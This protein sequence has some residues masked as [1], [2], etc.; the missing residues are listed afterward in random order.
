MSS[1]GRWI[2]QSAINRIAGNTE[3]PRGL[4]DVIPCLGIG[5]QHLRAMP[6]LK[7]PAVLG[8]RLRT[9][10]QGGFRIVND[11]IL[12]LKGEAGQHIA[13]FANIA[14]P[15]AFSEVLD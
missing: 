13:Q 1:L 8:L 4:A 5:R 10:D 6:T 3:P 2:V 11:G 15:S 12:R 7:G 9:C 14:G